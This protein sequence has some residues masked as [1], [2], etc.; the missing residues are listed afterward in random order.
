MS[1][2]PKHPNIRPGSREPPPPSDRS[3]RYAPSVSSTSDQSHH[4]HH[5]SNI[6]PT[7]A[8]QSNPEEFAF[9]RPADNAAV[10]ALFERVRI[11]RNLEGVGNL[12]TE[13]KWL[14]VQSNEQQMWREEKQRLA[15]AK[16]VASAGSQAPNVY[17][18][19]TPEWY[20]KKF[21][22][23]TVTHKHVAS[24]AVSLRTFEIK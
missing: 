18:Q 16:K 17:A 23:L 14:L 7:L 3:S 13:Q 2:G 5:L 21:M 11:S 24:L 19:G 1:P 9:E 20:L 4:S 22:D 10:D 15:H 12:S 6:F 8:G